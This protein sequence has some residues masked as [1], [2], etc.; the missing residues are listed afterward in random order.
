MKKVNKFI[1]MILRNY[2][3][4][5]LTKYI[6]ELFKNQLPIGL[7]NKTRNKKNILLHVKIIYICT[8]YIFRYNRR[9]N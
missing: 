3:N 6:Q 9:S 4:R 5:C 2:F 7:Q 1:N 8:L